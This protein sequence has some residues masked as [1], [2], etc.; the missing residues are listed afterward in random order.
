ML[1][2]V[3]LASAG[4]QSGRQAPGVGETRQGPIPRA[5]CQHVDRN[6]KAVFDYRLG[7]Q[8]LQ[9]V[10][11][12]RSQGVAP[13]QPGVEQRLDLTGPGRRKR[14]L[15]Q[16]WMARWQEMGWRRAEGAPSERPGR[17]SGPLRQPRDV[18]GRKRPKSLAPEP[19][20][21]DIGI[22]GVVKDRVAAL[23]AQDGRG[24]CRCSPVRHV[25]IIDHVQ[26]VKTRAQRLSHGH[27]LRDRDRSG[28]LLHVFEAQAQRSGRLCGVGPF[29][30]LRPRAVIIDEIDICAPPGRDQCGGDD[31]RIQPAGQLPQ[32]SPMARRQG[33]GRPVDDGFKRGGM[34]VPVPGGRT[35]ALRAPDVEGC[36]MIAGQTD[37]PR[38]NRRQ[39]AHAEA[40]CDQGRIVDKV[41][42]SLPVNR[43]MVRP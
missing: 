34:V 3:A 11:L 8:G 40:V 12:A 17:R 26:S 2:Q 28:M 22:G 36:G 33:C 21:D 5:L 13:E 32:K 7:Q 25:R 15:S 24:P 14:L 42:D 16:P 43:G 39:P 41:P 31:G 19:V 23:A 27:Q 10:G 30:P 1:C 6:G 35:E 18:G 29:V 38:P 4:D 9:Q 20:D 37:L